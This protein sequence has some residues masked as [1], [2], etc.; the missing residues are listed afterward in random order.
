ML[1][2][3]PS[4]DIWR[5]LLKARALASIALLGGLAVGLAGCNFVT[6]QATTN[7]YDPSD[8]VSGNV[9]QVDLRNAVAIVNDEGDANLV[10]TAVNRSD[11]DI[12]L[13]VQYESD[14]DKQNVTVKLKPGANNVGYGKKGQKLLEDFDPKAG[15][16]AQLY[17]VYGNQEGL[18]LGVPVLDTTFAEYAEHGPTAKPSPSVSP[19]GTPSGTPSG[20]ASTPA[21]GTEPS[22]TPSGEASQP[23]TNG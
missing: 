8:G 11:D 15:A 3:A 10:L 16:L 7:H 14:G 13:R 23:A 19:S 12:D 4:S 9:G 20:E 22:G 18:Q 5:V 21:D 2:L 1:S 17:F 6:P